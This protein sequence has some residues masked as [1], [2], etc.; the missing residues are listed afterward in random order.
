[1]ILYNA[2]SSY[3]SMIGRYSLLE[4][5][6]PFEGRRMDIHIAKEQ[7]SPW[8]LAINPAMTV[9][10][11]TDGEQSWLDS[12]TILKFAA[13]RAGDR[14]MDADPALSIPIEQIVQAHYD[15]PIERL[16]FGKALVRIPP[17]RFIVPR[18]LRSIIHKLEGDL[19]HSTSTSA[20]EAKIALN[21]ERLAYF[22]EGNL[23][24]KLQI[25]RDRI[26][27]FIKGL[28]EP[29]SLLFGDKPSSADI[30]TAVL[31]GRLKM[32]GEYNLLPQTSPLIMWFERV[33]LRPAYREAD[34]WTHFQPL[35][36]LLKR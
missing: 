23:V 15:L 26:Q 24:D 3:Y 1:M 16:T 17:L 22:T 33:Q 36:I 25:E 29:A 20:T 2:S 4:A 34:I 13:M 6:V 28:P 8:Y 11:L 12:Q 32:I 31:F 18:M 35:R 21:R 19:A 9:P 14:W 7:L 30:L 5:G 27:Q 10:T